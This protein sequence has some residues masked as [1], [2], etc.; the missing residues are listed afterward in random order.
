MLLLL[1]KPCFARVHQHV[2]IG[3]DT[4][5]VYFYSPQDA[6]T[7]SGNL[8]VGINAICMP[9]FKRYAE[10][11]F[12]IAALG[13]ESHLPID[14][15]NESVEGNSRRFNLIHCSRLSSMD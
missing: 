14:F 6:A 13:S 1:H 3:C 7:V 10:V 12:C 5:P 9:I 8:L 2:K 11:E 4:V 15:K